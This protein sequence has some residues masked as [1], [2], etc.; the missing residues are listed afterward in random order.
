[1]TREI[2]SRKIVITTNSTATISDIAM[3]S[4]V[5]T[6]DDSTGLLSKGWMSTISSGLQLRTMGKFADTKGGSIKINS[7]DFIAT[8]DSNNIPLTGSLI[9]IVDILDG[10]EDSVFTGEIRGLPEVQEDMTVI[11]YDSIIGNREV[12]VTK[13]LPDSSDYYPVFMGNGYQR[14]QAVG[15]DEVE[16]TLSDG[17][18]PAFV[19]AYSS[20]YS[21]YIGASLYPLISV[22]PSEINLLISEFDRLV[23]EGYSLIFT[24]NGNSLNLSSYSVFTVGGTGYLSSIEVLYQDGNYSPYN[25][26]IEYENKG[27]FSAVKNISYGD[28]DSTFNEP[29]RLYNYENSYIPLPD[30]TDKVAVNSEDITTQVTDIDG[31]GYTRVVPE[32]IEFVTSGN[33]P[34]WL[35]LNGTPLYDDKGWWYDIGSIRTITESGA[36][37]S[38][39]I[40]GDVDFY[41]GSRFETDQVRKANLAMKIKFPPIKKLP[42][43]LFFTGK[44][45]I[46]G[47]FALNTTDDLLIE[48][49]I[50]WKY[51]NSEDAATPNPEIVA[52]YWAPDD[53]QFVINTPFP[54]LVGVPDTLDGAKHFRYNSGW[55]SVSDDDVGDAMNGFSLDLIPLITDSEEYS[56]SA[57]FDVYV[58][59]RVQ[60]HSPFSIDISTLNYDY[61]VI[62][63]VDFSVDELYSPS[64]SGRASTLQA[65]YIDAV[66]RSMLKANLVTPPLEGWGLE[67]ATVGDWETIYKASTIAN[68]FGAIYYQYKNVTTAKIKADILRH[69]CCVGYVGR[70]G[71]EGVYQP[72][73]VMYN[74]DGVIL[75]LSDNYKGSL[76]VITKKQPTDIYPVLSIAYNTNV[77]TEKQAKTVDVINATQYSSTAVVGDELTDSEKRELWDYSNVLYRGWGSHAKLS[78]SES[79]LFL[80]TDAADVMEYARRFYA[81]QGA[82]TYTVNGSEYVDAYERFTV[83]AIV[84][85]PYLLDN[86]IDNGSPIRIRRV[87]LSLL[88]GV[89]TDIKESEKTATL[90]M[91]CVGK[92]LTGTSSYVIVESGSQVD[93][94][95]ESG[96][97]A[98]NYI[99]GG[100]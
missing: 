62:Q 99:E 47:F 74:T 34:S 92:N 85:I 93:N 31:V 16:F 78:D 68:L 95:V 12:L 4:G 28:S 41:Y 18:T 6:L 13:K 14:F 52:E 46:D 72:S 84:D 20:G 61:S 40:D 9:Q 24:G 73:S 30:Y 51:A 2:V 37:L 22:S 88:S 50:D 27:V 98:I 33:K 53:S 58:V 35:D 70:D 43:S 63:E 79:K 56:L 1:M 100:N 66:K 5:I 23:D 8:L 75:E 44:T 60:T 96:D 57:G 91:E 87:D 25:G 54:T 77:A 19:V 86:S 26:G 32:A 94:I 29:P 82:I 42:S 45:Y 7:V 80:F 81:L 59:L 17:A 3:V 48:V 49:W 55:N 90:T 69:C 36:S 65:A 39:V 89:V 71:I 67:Q 11:H 10:V 64:F 76:P 38:T 21:A 83:T 97:R 15:Y